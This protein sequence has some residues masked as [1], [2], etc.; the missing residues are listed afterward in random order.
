MTT[1]VHCADLHLTSGTESGY[2][3]NVLDEILAL[4]ESEK[5][6]AL[7][8]AGDLFDSF[9]DLVA[10]RAE[11]RERIAKFCGK[12]AVVFVP[13]NH[14]MLRKGNRTLSSYDLAPAIQMYQEPFGQKT[15]C[16]FEIL[17]IPHQS[18]Y[19]GYNEWKVSK[20]SHPRIV[21]FH[22]L[23]NG[24]DIYTGPETLD[25]EE[26]GSAVDTDIFARC[27]ADYAALGHIHTKKLKTFGNLIAGY[28]GSARVWRRGES[29]ARGVNILRL[30]DMIEV[31][32]A[33]LKSAG[34]YRFYDLHVGMKGDLPGLDELKKAWGVNDWIGINLRGIVESESVASNLSESIISGSR[35]LVRSIEV[36]RDAIRPV[37]GILGQ[38]IARQFV[39]K[40]KEREQDAAEKGSHTVW[41]KALEMGLSEIAQ[42]VEEASND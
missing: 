25:D 5:A 32:W 42:A 3:L 39:E 11:F 1:V 19:A 29:G 22:G 24:M 36:S 4:A 12:S 27:E 20:K 13:G 33:P 15:F 34:E 18:S 37:A 26:G 41:A 7:I 30:G 10:L 35:G 9:D 8:V 40:M 28:P 23:V 2:S 21:V 31:E 17:S 16:R 6:E 14:D 38:P